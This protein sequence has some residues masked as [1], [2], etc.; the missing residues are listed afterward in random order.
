MANFS[1]YDRRL[2]LRQPTYTTDASNHPVRTYP[3]D[4]ASVW[5]QRVYDRANETYNQQQIEAT[6]FATFRTRY[7]SGVDETWQ[8]EDE[9]NGLKYDI[10]A[11]LELGRKDALEIKG[12][13][14]VPGA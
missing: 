13:T 4:T 14:H 11:V 3:S 10:L 2:T 6:R 8:L 7:H 5:G 9:S 1:R 12:Y